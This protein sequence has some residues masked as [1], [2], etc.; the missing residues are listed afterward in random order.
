MA[1]SGATL[2]AVAPSDV[3]AHGAAWDTRTDLA[4]FMTEACGSCSAPSHVSRNCV[5]C[6]IYSESAL[7][8]QGSTFRIDHVV[9]HVQGPQLKPQLCAA[10]VLPRNMSL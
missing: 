2:H 10:P 7:V 9:R 1:R 4:H 6:S 8:S 5:G 3:H